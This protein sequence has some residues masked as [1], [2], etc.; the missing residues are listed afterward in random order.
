[1]TFRPYCAHKR[2]KK[3]NNIKHVKSIE[4]TNDHKFWTIEN[5]NGQLD[6]LTYNQELEQIK[7]NNKLN[8]QKS[9]NAM[10]KKLT[11]NGN[12]DLSIRNKIISRRYP[13][14]E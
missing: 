7:N 5:A 13:Y 11:N 6:Q 12:V 10:K 9:K 8:E 4:P 3:T 14:V 2:Y 1:M